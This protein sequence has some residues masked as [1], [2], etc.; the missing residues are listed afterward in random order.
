MVPDN[1]AADTAEGEVAAGSAT[2]ASG[3]KNPKEKVA[4]GAG[5]VTD[6]VPTAWRVAMDN[7]VSTFPTGEGGVDVAPASAASSVGGITESAEEGAEGVTESAEEGAAEVTESAEEG[8]TG[9]TESAEEGAAEVTESA[10]EGA[11]GVTE[12]AEEGA[13]GVTESAEEGAVSQDGDRSDE[14]GAHV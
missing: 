5:T 10:E 6:A 9:V 7:D 11:T 2:G 4:A 13:G 8:A 12:S 14:G 3:L 1:S